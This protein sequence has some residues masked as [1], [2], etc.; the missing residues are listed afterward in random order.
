MVALTSMSG[1]PFTFCMMTARSF[2]CFSVGC[3]GVA[4]VAGAAGAGELLLEDML[5]DTCRVWKRVELCNV[6]R[7]GRE[8]GSCEVGRWWVSFCESR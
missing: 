8:V 2:I 6:F 1:L 4:G 3:L 5:E 7:E